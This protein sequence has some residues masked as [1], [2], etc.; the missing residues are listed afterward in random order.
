M[1]TPH[2]FSLLFQQQP[3]LL[4]F[5]LQQQQQ[6][7]QQGG[8]VSAAAASAAAA[9]KQAAE[10]LKPTEAQQAHAVSVQQHT[11]TLYPRRSREA[12]ALAAAEQQQQQQQQSEVSP[13]LTRR[14]SLLPLA[15]P[16][17]LLQRQTA[18]LPEASGSSPNQWCSLQQQHLQQQQQ[19]VA[20]AATAAT[21]APAA[22]N[23]SS[24]SYGRIMKTG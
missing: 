8:A 7:Q 18:V 4:A 9:T 14:F 22:R 24:S 1:Q 23:S 2:A 5:Q 12:A 13:H 15:A 19:P 11:A 16:V 10:R 6:Q 17:A 21:A 20:A 3:E